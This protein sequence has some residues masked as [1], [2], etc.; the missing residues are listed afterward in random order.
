MLLCGIEGHICVFQTCAELL[1]KGHAVHLIRDCT[2]SQRKEDLDVGI[3]R[4]RQMGAIVSTTE[5]A[6]FELMK[7]ADMEAGSVFRTVS[8]LLVQ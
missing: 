2:S 4:M 6:L 5:M 8:R 7:Y 1:G 3:D